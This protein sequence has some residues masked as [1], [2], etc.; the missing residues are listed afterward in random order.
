MKADSVHPGYGFLSENSS[1]AQ[2]C[3]L[4]V[5]IC[6]VVLR[7]LLSEHVPACWL[8]ANTIANTFCS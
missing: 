6:I 4:L 5:E 1:F 2:L 7:K 3:T 8:E